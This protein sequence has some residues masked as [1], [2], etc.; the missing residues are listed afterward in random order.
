MRP[1]Y[2]L[3]EF[4][5]RDGELGSEERFVSFEKIS[6]SFQY[7]H[8]FPFGAIFPKAREKIGRFPVFP[9]IVQLGG[10]V[11]VDFSFPKAREKIGRFRVFSAIEQLGGAIPDDFPV[12][13]VF[14]QQQES[15]DFPDFSGRQRTGFQIV[16][17]VGKAH[18]YHER[19]PGKRRMRPNGA[20]GF[21]LR[22]LAPLH[23]GA[24]RE[25]QKM[26]AFRQGGSNELQ[27]GFRTVRNIQCVENASEK[28]RF[29]FRIFR[30]GEFFQ[31]EFR[32]YRIAQGF[33]RDFR[34]SL[35]N[36]F[37]GIGEIS[38]ALLSGDTEEQIHGFGR[39]DQIGVFRDSGIPGRLPCL[40]QPAENRFRY[41]RIG[42]SETGRECFDPGHSRNDIPEFPAFYFQKVL[43]QDIR[44]LLV[45]PD[46]VGQGR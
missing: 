9:A 7:F 32:E 35:Q 24:V 31:N 15:G 11:P 44:H 46:F 18:G 4:P 26:T 22:G 17:E 36:P 5:V 10:A 37:R 28:F 23:W 41:R 19:I 42:V 21:S 30:F 14:G 45:L 12:R 6:R 20:E 40:G 34:E 38:A 16:P 3:A 27:M 39:S 13:S 29:A 2:S 33:F 25:F 8:A 43:F 1:F